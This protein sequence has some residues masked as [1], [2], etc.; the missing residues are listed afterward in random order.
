MF[1]IFNRYSIWYKTTNICPFYWKL[2][3]IEAV[4]VM[5]WL[6]SIRWISSTITPSKLRNCNMV[7]LKWVTSSS[8]SDGEMI[9][10]R[11]MMTDLKFMNEDEH[12]HSHRT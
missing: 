5:V 7:I 4:S 2:K 12:S 11:M 3:I 9:S 6:V 1:D 8:R 10:D